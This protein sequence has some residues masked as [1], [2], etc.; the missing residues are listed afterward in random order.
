MQ[1]KYTSKQ[2]DK[3]GFVHFTPA[4]D[5]IWTTLIQRQ[6][7]IVKGRACDEYIVGLDKLNFSEHHIP[8]PMAVSETLLAQTGWQVE[9][10]AAVIPEDAFFTLL[11]NKKFPVATFI[12][13]EEDLDYIEEPDIF[14]EL[15]GHCPLLTNQK[16]ADFV[17][18]YG[19]LALTQSKKIRRLLFRLFW[20]TIEFGLIQTPKG[21]RIYGG[22]ILS[23]FSET[24]SAL[25]DEN[26]HRPFVALDALR[27]PFRID[28]VQPIY[29]IINQMK[30]LDQL[31]GE[32]VLKEAQRAQGLGDFLPHANIN[33][34]KG[35]TDG[36]FAC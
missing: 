18:A 29:Y 30:D 5:A 24:Q 35:E 19:Q 23:S 2:P 16:Y 3:H 34:R 17:E 6:N 11:A 36:K 13:R 32:V 25:S 33:Q 26:I 8:Q 7:E 10:V 20:F 12:R 22:G 28:I 31:L 1:T 27:T 14:H 21:L 15:Y 4:E 9:P